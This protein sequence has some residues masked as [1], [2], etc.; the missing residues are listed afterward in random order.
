MV[1]HGATEVVALWRILVAAAVRLRSTEPAFAD[2]L[3]QRDGRQEFSASVGDWL[4]VVRDWLA[5]WSG[6]V[7]ETVGHKAT[8]AILAASEGTDGYFGRAG[9]RHS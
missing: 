1:A 4:S 3:A 7:R 8:P 9:G 2:Q 5:A 6:N